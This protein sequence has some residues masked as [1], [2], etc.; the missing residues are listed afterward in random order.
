M[1]TSL[2]INAPSVSKQALEPWQ[3]SW[4]AKKCNYTKLKASVG[5]AHWLMRSF[6]SCC[7]DT[8][9]LGPSS[10]DKEVEDSDT[11]NIEQEGFI[12]LTADLVI[13]AADDQAGL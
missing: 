13:A 4:H 3:R 5:G 2:G 12:D 10:P 8:S 1:E 7:S 9:S 11:K 6:V